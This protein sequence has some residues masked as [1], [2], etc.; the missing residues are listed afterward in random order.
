MVWFTCFFDFSISC[1]LVVG[2]GDI[3]SFRGAREDLMAGG[4]ST[5]CP[6]VSLWDA[7]AV[8]V[9]GSMQSCRLPLLI[10]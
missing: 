1:E 8:T 2:S 3:I 6:N 10:L 7:A 9:P 4:G 5:E